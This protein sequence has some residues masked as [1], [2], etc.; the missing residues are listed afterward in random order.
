MSLSNTLKRI[1]NIKFNFLS[2]AVGDTSFNLLDVGAGNRSASK[3][4]AVFPLCNYYGLDM[5]RNT[6]YGDNDFK[7]MKDF[8]EL[9]VKNKSTQEQVLNVDWED[10]ALSD[11]GILYIGDIG[12]NFNWR[13]DLGIYR[14]DLKQAF[15]DPHLLENL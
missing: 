11:Q 14:I 12:N 4:M 2:K 10:I 13:K 8:Y 9:I 3:T 5:D 7:L 15:K 1:V 6:D